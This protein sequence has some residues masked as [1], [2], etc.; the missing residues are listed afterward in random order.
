MKVTR[1]E[2][3]SHI[4][5]HSGIVGVFDTPFLLIDRSSRQWLNRE[6]LELHDIIN[7]MGLTDTQKIIPSA[8]Q[9]L[10]LSP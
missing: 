10:Q 5:S 9:Y 2:L 6:I 4:D 1:L 3:K 7:Q 8:Q